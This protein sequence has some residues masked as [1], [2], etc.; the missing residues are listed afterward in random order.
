[1]APASVR[2]GGTSQTECQLGGQSA[3]RVSNSDASVLTPLPAGVHVLDMVRNWSETLSGGEQQRLGFARLL[4]H[5]P[6]FA[7]LDESTASMDVALEEHC[8]RLL[9]S[10]GITAVS[11]GHRP[12]LVQFHTRVLRLDGSGGYTVMTVT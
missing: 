8:M 11:V 5:A 10:R 9:S 1:M 12:T 3:V 7:L 2:T 6:M 4:Y